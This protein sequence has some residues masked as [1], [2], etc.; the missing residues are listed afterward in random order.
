MTHL[1]NSR[2]HIMSLMRDD[3]IDGSSIAERARQLDL[4]RH[5]TARWLSTL[6]QVR[7]RE[8]ARVARRT[9]NIEACGTYP[10]RDAD[11]GEIHVHEAHDDSAAFADVEPFICPRVSRRVR[12]ATCLRWLTPKRMTEADLRSPDERALVGQWGLFART[13][14]PAG[15]CLGVYGGQL[16]DDV[17]VFLLQDDRYLMSA[18]DVLGQVAINGENIMSLMNTLF[19]LDA[20]GRVVGHPADGY[21]VAGTV[22]RVTLRHGWRARVHAFHA[23]EDVAAGRE[24]RWNYGLGQG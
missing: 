5:G 1:L 24:L 6:R 11:H 9:F 3:D 4:V 19:E 23:S 16:L 22:H 17:D 15:T 18:S 10:F 12:A 21:N 20:D 8:R 13:T 2:D 14:I 7:F